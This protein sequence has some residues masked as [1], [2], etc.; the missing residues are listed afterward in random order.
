M[1]TQYFDGPVVFRN[2]T[3]YSD[4]ISTSISTTTSSVPVQVLSITGQSNEV[5]VYDGMFTG[6]VSSGPQKGRS[7]FVKYTV[8]GRTVLGVMQLYKSNPG[9]I[10]MTIV[11]DGDNSLDSCLVT[12]TNLGNSISVRVIG[13]PA[14]QMTWAMTHR[15][16]R[17]N[18]D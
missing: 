13:L 9:D 15:V 5:I 1:S 4:T 17:M 14:T 11:R 18:Q 3:K 10:P 7:I 16:T 8:M 6:F 2:G 12:T